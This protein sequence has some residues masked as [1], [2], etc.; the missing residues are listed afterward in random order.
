MVLTQPMADGALHNA[1]AALRNSPIG[2]ARTIRVA[3]LD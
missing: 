3:Q 2:H 1:L